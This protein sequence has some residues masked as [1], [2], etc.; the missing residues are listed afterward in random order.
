M[1][2]KM[3]KRQNKVKK[4][5]KKLSMFRKILSSPIHDR[6]IAEL[7]DSDNVS[8]TLKFTQRTLWQNCISEENDI[9]NQVIVRCVITSNVKDEMFY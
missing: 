6:A 8:A 5:I 3:S 1:A 7:T 2:T 9:M 4:R